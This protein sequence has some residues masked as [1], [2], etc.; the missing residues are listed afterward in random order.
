MVFDKS[1][2]NNRV[3]DTSEPIDDEDSKVGGAKVSQ[4]QE[5]REKAQ[6]EKPTKT[7]LLL[8]KNLKEESMFLAQLNNQSF[9]QYFIDA[10]KTRNE[11]MKKKAADMMANKA[12]EYLQQ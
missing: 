4:L 12:K 9:T 6:R 8:P 7:S 5:D 10:L 1:K 3:V 11:E 2:K